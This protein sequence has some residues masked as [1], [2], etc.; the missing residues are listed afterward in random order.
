MG[1]ESTGKVFEVVIQLGAILAV[2]VVLLFL[3]NWRA[4]LI[5]L[6]TSWTLTRTTAEWVELLEHAAVPCSPILDVGQVLTH[7]HTQA[8]GMTIAAST[9]GAPPMVANPMRLDGQRPQN[10]LPPPGLDSLGGQSPW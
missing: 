2:L 4:T 3:R 8:R 6:I 1:F 7:P 9:D 5:P 10:P